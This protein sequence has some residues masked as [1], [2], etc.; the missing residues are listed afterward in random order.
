MVTF[1]FFCEE[2]NWIAKD[3]NYFP[4]ERVTKAFRRGGSWGGNYLPGEIK[5]GSPGERNTV[6]KKIDPKTGNME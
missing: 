5:A 2:R 3:I 6:S 4:R 1:Y